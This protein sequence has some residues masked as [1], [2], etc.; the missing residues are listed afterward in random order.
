MVRDQKAHLFDSY[1]SRYSFSFCSFFLSGCYR[2]PRMRSPSRQKKPKKGT[3]VGKHGLLAVHRRCLRK[4]PAC[5]KQESHMKA[6]FLKH[7]FCRQCHHRARVTWS[8]ARM[9]LERPKKALSSATIEELDEAIEYC[10]IHQVTCKELKIFCEHEVGW[11]FPVSFPSMNACAMKRKC[12]FG[13]MGTLSRFL[14][15]V[16]HSP[17]FPLVLSMCFPFWFRRNL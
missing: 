2:R 15:F 1:L 3:W 8:T 12:V 13:G 4:C 16:P 17:L 14:D 6:E 11:G 9:G 10:S 7:S 5:M